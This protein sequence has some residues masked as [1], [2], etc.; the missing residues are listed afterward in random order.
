MQSAD[1][2]GNLLQVKGLEEVTKA[3][4]KIRLSNRFAL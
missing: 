2:D 4:E 1:V 3:E